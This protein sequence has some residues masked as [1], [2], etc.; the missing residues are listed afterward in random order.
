MTEAELRQEIAVALFQQG[1]LTAGQASR[2]AET[3][4]L[5]FQHLLASRGVAP[6]YDV[7]DFEDDLRTPPR[8]GPA[9]I[10]V[11][12]ASPLVALSAVGRVDLL[13]SLYERVVVPEAVDGEVAAAGADAPGASVVRAA[14]WIEVRRVLDQRLVQALLGDV[15]RGE[16]E[17]ITLAVE[18]G[19]DLLLTDERRGR[20]VAARL[21]QR[22]VGAC[23]VLVEAK[24]KGL[25]PAVRPVLDALAS[26]AGFRIGDRLRARVLDAAGE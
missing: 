15:D 5:R 19:A 4:R 22:V 25:L 21:H 8:L 16:A 23:G 9:L 12:D 7:E 14:D 10:V 3:D 20:A 26:D 6:H 11:S 17:A 13:R 18:T 1:R 2:L 24:A